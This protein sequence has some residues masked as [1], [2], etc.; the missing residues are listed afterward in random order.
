M[1]GRA[2][3]LVNRM[4]YEARRGRGVKPRQIEPVVGDIYSSIQRNPHAFNGRMRCR[5]DNSSLF[6]HALAVCGLL[7]LEAGGDHGSSPDPALRSHPQT[8]HDFLRAGGG[9]PDEVAQ[10]CLEHHERCDVT[11]A[12][13]EP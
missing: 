11:A 7:Q 8:G 5:R 9:V 10:A 3:K 2:G 12:H 6:Q 1:A 13:S 4:F